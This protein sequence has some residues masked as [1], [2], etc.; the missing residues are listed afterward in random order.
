MLLDSYFK[1]ENSLMDGERHILN[2]ALLPDHEIY[3]G[4]FPGKPVSPGVCSIQMIRECAEQVLGCRLSII[5]L[6]QCRFITLLTPLVAS[7]LSIS[8]SAVETADGYKL[9]AD[10]SAGDVAFV[11][12]KGDFG[13]K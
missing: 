3:K 7:K 4:H 11:S 10:I 13:K 1:I 9:V 2:V 5:N 6:Q 8:M 12:L